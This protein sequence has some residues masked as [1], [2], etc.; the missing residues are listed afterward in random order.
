MYD[1][2]LVPTDGSEH[3]ERA[4]R[5][6]LALAG[7]FDA[8]VHVLGVVDV[9]GVAGPFD[10]GG[11]SPEFVDR[12]EAEAEAGVD[13]VAALAGADRA[14]ETDVRE[15]KPAD[16]VLDYVDEAGIDFVAMGT[17]GRSGLSRFVS[18]SVT[19]QVVRNATVPVVTARLT[20]A[21]PVTDYG[22]VLVPTDGSDAAAAA[23]DHGIAVAGAFDAT[24]HALNVVDVG[25]VA[26][27]S[28][29]APTTNLLD[30][31]VERGEGATEDV[32]ERV[33]DAGIE[34][35]TEVRRGFPS[36]DLLDYVDE[37][38]IDLVAMGTHGR[39]GVD[40]LLLG[41][42][43]EHTIRRSPVPVLSVHPDAGAGE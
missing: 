12:L 43:T 37:A 4:A 13:D 41:S 5:H 29:V 11:V 35:V 17:R 39:T 34:A 33:R 19:E 8:T 31:L 36:A 15:G 42:T 14:V 18:G 38:G 22:R 7:A 9:A 3:A 2:I 10:A 21:D 30:S 24:V 25:A 1:R 20:D 28:E 32:A 40:R 26:A 27:G 23:V 16:A 6:A